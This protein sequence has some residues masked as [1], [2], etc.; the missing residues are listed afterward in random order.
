VVII[1]SMG[2]PL[3]NELAFSCLATLHG[4]LTWIVRAFTPDP[5]SVSTPSTPRQ[6]NSSCTLWNRPH[7][8]TYAL[9]ETERTERRQEGHGGAEWQNPSRSVG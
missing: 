9:T 6:P 5:G 4:V 8:S 3:S 2:V 7:P 1:E